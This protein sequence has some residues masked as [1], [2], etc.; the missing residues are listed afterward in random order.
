MNG[1]DND[2][3]VILM[4]YAFSSSLVDDTLWMIICNI[5]SENN[6]LTYLLD[7][8]TLLCFLLPLFLW[9]FGWLRGYLVA[10]YI[11][12]IVFT[13]T[14]VLIDYLSYFAPLTLL[15]FRSLKSCIHPISVLFY[16]ALLI[17]FLICMYDIFL[18]KDVS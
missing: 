9:F 14:L 17:T 1:N 15:V 7:F 6:L 16:I 4:K 10:L 18:F 3:K 5:F 2:L 12:I 11:V 13:I 8:V